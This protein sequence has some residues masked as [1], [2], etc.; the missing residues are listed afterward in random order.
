MNATSSYRKFRVKLKLLYP[1]STVHYNREQ[2][3]IILL[4]QQNV[5]SIP[6]RQTRIAVGSIN[7][8]NNMYSYSSVSCHLNK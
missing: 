1:A 5:L 7:S 4:P 2:R 6:I 3:I 8:Y